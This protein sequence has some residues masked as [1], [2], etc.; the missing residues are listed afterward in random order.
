MDRLT[1]IK[2]L[3]LGTAGFFINPSMILAATQSQPLRR[4]ILIELYGGN[5][6][7]NTVIPYTNSRY[8]QL[9]PTLGIEKQELLKLDE[10]L[11]LHPALKPL[12]RLWGEQSMGI[13]SGVGY[14]QPNRS[15][16][17][18][19]EIW[20]TA[21]NAEEYLE[22]GWLSQALKGLSTKQYA[23]EGLILGKEDAGPL[24][25]KQIRSIAL[26]DPRS[27]FRQAKR[28]KQIQKQTSNPSLAHLLHVQENIQQAAYQLNQKLAKAPKLKTKFPQHAIGKQLEWTARL[29]ASQVNI[30]IIKL[31]H[32]SFDTHSNQKTTH[33]RLLK[34]LAEGLDSFQQAMI[35]THQWDQVLIMSYSEFGRRVKENASR[36]TDHGTAAPQFM[37][38]GKV[39]G[40]LYGQYPSLENLDNGDLVYSIDFRQLYNTVIK[41][42]WKI[43]ISPFSYKN[44]PAIDCI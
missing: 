1:F 3:I 11:G 43:R 16:F 23:T 12:M 38:G 40:G 17:R 41:H 34:Q 5:D 22:E 14:P 19:I 37:W 27:F 31:S 44:Y 2:T 8:Y 9:R 26:K 10:E 20:E 33:H 25:G 21:S 32:G 4:F 7:L 35:E 42:W 15:H 29:I 36:G 39:K 13:I 28:L 24:S 18:S 6:G 30:P